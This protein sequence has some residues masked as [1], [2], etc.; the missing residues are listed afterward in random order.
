MDIGFSFKHT[1]CS[2][3]LHG[4]TMII[5]FNNGAKLISKYLDDSIIYPAVYYD[6]YGISKYL[7]T[8]EDIFNYS[9]PPIIR[10]DRFDD[11]VPHDF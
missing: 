5:Q 11:L 10:G 2:Y 1:E 9:R 6:S 4:N 7:Y 8:L 3:R